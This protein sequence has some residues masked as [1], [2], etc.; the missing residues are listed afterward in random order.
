MGTY[1][2]TQAA[3][4]IQASRWPDDR[5]IDTILDRSYFGPDAIGIDAA[6]RRYYARPLASLD[7]SEVAL[8][9]SLMWSPQALDPW[10]RADRLRKRMAA[11][12]G[13]DAAQ[14]DAAFASLAPRPT[15]LRCP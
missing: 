9:V 4:A 7:D 14:I 15:H 13:L 1:H 10:C 3:M 11:R 6:A 5:I 12:S 2:L 8:L